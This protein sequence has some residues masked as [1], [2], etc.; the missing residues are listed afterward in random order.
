MLPYIVF[1]LEAENV[2][3]CLQWVCA[4]QKIA[5]YIYIK[6]S[7]TVCYLFAGRILSHHWKV[8]SHPFSHQRSRHTSSPPSVTSYTTPSTKYH[9]TRHQPL[10]TTSRTSSAIK[11]HVTRHQPPTVTSYTSS[12]ITGHATRHQPPTV[13]SYT[14]PATRSHVTRHEPSNVTSHAISSSAWRRTVSAAPV[15]HSRRSVLI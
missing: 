4:D 11:G 12:A 3:K 9:V 5:I 15:S 8:T 13:T 10:N 2:G 6:F 1:S 14:S 7:S